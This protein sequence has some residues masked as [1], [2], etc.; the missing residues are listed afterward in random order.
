MHWLTAVLICL[1]TILFFIQLY[2]FLNRPNDQQRGLYLVLLFLLLHFNIANGLFPDPT[3]PLNI[4]FQYM[5][6]YGFAYLM[7]AYQPFYLYKAYRLKR[8][9]WWATWGSLLFILLPYGIFNVIAY[10]V[11]GSITLDKQIGVIIPGVY[12]LVVLAVMLR[13]IRLKYQEKGNKRLYVCE[14]VVW[15]SFLPWEAMT[16]FA[17]ITAPQWLKLLMGN[18]GWLIITFVQFGIGIKVSRK[19]NHHYRE[20]TASVSEADFVEGCRMLGLSDREI[21]VAVLRLKGM[22]RQ[23]IADKLFISPHTVKT[24]ITNINEKT[25]AGNTNEL[26]RAVLV[27]LDKQ[28]RN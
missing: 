5:L 6:A 20:L 8:L 3:F 2:H 24:H 14:L 1:E 15:A 16:A 7:G 27:A 17:F 13:A 23:E 11:N 19:E 25:G 22:S 9:R 26:I 10:D 21:D 28:N 18:I 4:K 12:G